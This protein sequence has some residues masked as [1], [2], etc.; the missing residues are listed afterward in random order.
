M[1]LWTPP[2]K[3]RARRGSWS[4]RRSGRSA[5]RPSRCPSP[6]GRA[7]RGWRGGRARTRRPRRGG[8]GTR[9]DWRPPRARARDARARQA[10]SGTYEPL[11]APLEAELRAFAL[12]QGLEAALVGDALVNLHVGGGIVAP[13]HPAPAHAALLL[14]EREEG[15]DAQAETCHLF[16]R[17]LVV[18]VVVQTGITARSSS[19]ARSTTTPPSNAC[20]GRRSLPAG[21]RSCTMRRFTCP[22]YWA[23]ATISWP[24]VH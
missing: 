24:G 2:Q 15:L 9:R 7:R 3:A 18:D 11:D 12:D 22:R 16:W 17:N 21:A 10:G 8:H 6:R 5:P 23:R 4:P 20:P 14:H 1:P 13:A 19:P